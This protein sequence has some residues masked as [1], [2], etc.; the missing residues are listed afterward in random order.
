MK[1]PTI[2]TLD[3]RKYNFKEY[4]RAT[5]SSLLLYK[6][7]IEREVDDIQKNFVKRDKKGNSIT[8]PTIVHDDLCKF[9]A[10]LDYLKRVLWVRSFWRPRDWLEKITETI[11]LWYSKIE[12]FWFA[13]KRKREQALD[14]EE[15]IAYYRKQV[16]RIEKKLMKLFPEDTSNCTWTSAE[17]A[18]SSPSQKQKDKAR[19][20]LSKRCYYLDQMFQ[21]TDVEI[22][23]LEEVNDTLR[24][25]TQFLKKQADD[26]SERDKGLIFDDEP[27]ENCNEANMYW[28][29]GAEGTI[30][31][32][33]GDDF[34]GSNFNRIIEIENSILDDSDLIP[35]VSML[36]YPEG[37][38]EEGNHCEKSITGD[39]DEEEEDWKTG[40]W[41]RPEFE[42]IKVCHAVHHLFDHHNLPIVD[43]LH[44]N[45]YHLEFKRENSLYLDITETHHPKGFGM[46]YRREEYEEAMKKIK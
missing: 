21:A 24:H 35:C 3:K 31:P 41:H 38:D 44:V 33:D 29:P 7:M 5:Y 14:K 30:L 23:R 37:E 32:Y 28:A 11:Q 15:R 9:Y 2:F 20:L 45:S 39:F 10:E 17:I 42:H 22:K 25:Y 46:Y 12:S 27:W 13:R 34:Y 4:W 43:I 16:Q 40:N 8:M 18:F 36:V 19:S 1:T 6:S 26:W